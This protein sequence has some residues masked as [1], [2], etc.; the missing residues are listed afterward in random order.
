MTS[1]CA[2]NSR[3]LITAVL[4]ATLYSTAAQA[5][6]KY[7][8]WEAEIPAATNFPKESPYAASTFE[9][10]RSLLSGGDWL[11]NAGVRT[12][13]EAFA[14]YR[15]TVPGDGE[16]DLWCRK[17]WKHGPFRWR[18]D[19]ADWW[20]CP[21]DV[22]LADDT[23]IRIHLG[24]NWVHLGKVTLTGGEHEFELRLL[25]GEGENLVA[26][27]DCF[28]LTRI[29]FVPRGKLKPDEKSG[30]A[31]PRMFPWEP[32]RDRFSRKALLD[33]RDLNETRA[34]RHG[35]VRRKGFDFVLG[36]G[37]PVRFWAVNA[38]AQIAG[39]D[40]TSIDYLARRLAKVGVNM[41]RYHSPVFGQDPSVADPKKLDDL[42][43]LVAALKR[44]GIY[45]KL[46]FYF[47]LWFDIK[48][49]YDVPGF[50]AIENKKPFAL[51]YFDPRVQ[52]FYKVWARALLTTKNPY[53]GMPL[54]QES[55]VA[56]VE[57][58]NEDSLFFWTF[59]KKNIPKLYWQRLE[60]LY[61]EWLQKRYSSPEEIRRA[62]L[63]AREPGDDPSG[64]W[65]VL[66]EAWHMTQG[67]LKGAGPGRR[68]RVGDQVRFLTEVQRRF[69]EDIIKYFREELGVRS[70]ISPSN[71]VVA[72]PA[73]LDA[74]ERYTY[75]AGDV[76]DRHGYFGGAHR[77]EGAGYSVR[78]GHEFKNLAAVRVPEKIPLQMIQI[79]Q[80]PSIISEIGWTNPNRYRAGF[81]FLAATYGALQGLDGIFAFALHGAFWETTMKKFGL[82]S[83]AIMGN[84]PAYALLYRRGDV[85]EAEVVVRQVLDLEDLYALKG[86]GG[87]AAQALDELRARDIPPGG[88]AVGEVSH[89]DP[90]AYYVGRVVRAFGE[91]KAESMEMNLATL[92]D[93]DRK[94]IRS[95]TGEVFWEY[96]KGIV[97]VDTKRSQG[98]AGFLSQL[99]KLELSRVTIES[100]NDYSTV[101]I[102]ALDRRPLES[103]R[104]ILIQVMT[105][106]S[107]YGFRASGGQDGRINEMGGWPFGVEKI[108]ARITLDLD[109]G[110]KPAVK[111]L[112]EHGYPRD[113]EVLTT[114]GA[115]GAPLVIQLLEDSVYH[116]VL[117]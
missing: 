104:R 54:A 48:P 74:L 11:T 73:L 81:A 18:F 58:V 31:N 105:V 96:E 103:S 50:E 19:A 95:L 32:S 92:I 53:T 52:E 69:Y 111:A 41:V 72:D 107:P 12:G 8:W 21:F 97:R 6:G 34:G 108:Q 67:G 76:I 85:K 106:E 100:E 27:F 36:N 94:T 68:K 44:E 93:R 28:V 91:E 110:R 20:V 63:E 64:G 89:I 5:A 70:L 39:L 56:I 29:P 59:T 47:P 4:L 17:F 77:G 23:Y 116:V 83:P 65:A 101:M 66:Y 60:N 98:A 88:V 79:D 90:L 37:K 7:V 99:A 87:F 62:W 115:D 82:A 80:Y 22:S 75:T 112:D 33:L 15:I 78:V 51:L 25:A 14:K 26:G 42:F 9:H 30:H 117:R 84:F 55:A 24:A 46:S 113:V 57:I 86:S 49:E 1:C 109:P 35:F 40:H 71:W 61:G 13:P 38:S 43:Y 114:G 2:G 102:T 45:T 10:K 16:Y 3:G